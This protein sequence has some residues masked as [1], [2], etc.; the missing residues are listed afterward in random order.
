MNLNSKQSDYITLKDDGSIDI[1]TGN[2]LSI[3]G[4]NWNLML[5]VTS[6]ESIQGDSVIEY[7]FTVTMIDRCTN[8]ELSDPSIVS[9]FDYFIAATGLRT[10]PTPTYT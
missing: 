1:D 9:D 5:K 8:D 4:Q 3:A 2:D 6:D 10:I 7:P